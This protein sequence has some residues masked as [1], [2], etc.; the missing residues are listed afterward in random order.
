M[1]TNSDKHKLDLPPGFSEI[2]LREHGDAFAHAQGVAAT[3]G[4][5]T[6]VWVRRLDSIETAVVLE[7][8]QPLAEARCA[9]FAVMNA[10]ADAL[11]Q[12][13]APEKALQFSW[14]DTIL[15]DGGI[16][17]GCRLAA[18]RDAADTDVPDWLVVGLQLRGSVPMTTW[19][20]FSRGTS[21]EAEGF[22]LLHSEDVLASF[23]RHLMAGFD[24]WRAD[25]F[26]SVAER[27][28]ARMPAIKGARRGLE[29][30][31]DL[32]ERRLA[33]VKEVVRQPLTEALDVPQW[34]DPDTGQPWL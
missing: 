10:A 11:G 18:P 6:L 5:G 21:L 14:P 19:Q 31:G 20:S 26:K 32:L 15:L 13:C 30:N 2:R 12:Y 34:L 27:F 16:V 33:T 28:L 29:R 22:D 25:G 1:T 7:P 9:L 8:E 3:E 23:T 4:A 17:G 24:G